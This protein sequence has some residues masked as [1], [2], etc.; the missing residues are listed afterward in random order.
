MNWVAIINIFGTINGLFFALVF[1][2][3]KRGNK[4]ANRILSLLFVN[5]ALISTGAFLSN[6]QLYQ[7]YTFLQRLGSPWFLAL[8]PLL[9]L[10]VRHLVISDERSNSKV[11]LHFLPII[12]NYLYNIPFYLRS[13][14]DK[15]SFLHSGPEIDVLVFRFL[16][17]V[18]FAVYTYL[19]FKDLKIYNKT[20]KD[21]YSSIESRQLNWILYLGLSILST[22]IVHTVFIGKI[23]LINSLFN[24]WETLIIMFLAFIGF[25]HPLIFSD[26]EFIKQ[27]I[28]IDKPVLPIDRQKQYL[29]LII[30]YVESKKIFLDSQ[31][32]LNKFSKDLG[33]PVSY[34]SNVINSQLKKNFFDFINYY[35]IEEAKSRLV[36]KGGNESILNIAFEVGFN[37]KSSF[38]SVFKKFVK[39]TPSQ[40]RKDNTK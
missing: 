31:L 27:L 28:R 6:A 35:R 2:R 16:Y 30:N 15:I 37:S 32:N 36:E 38:N 39:K 7:K 40:Y 34:C 18:H 1:F 14:D 19:I 26:Q 3:I 5:F 23:F 25:T 24:I 33:I 12:F 8:G 13:A 29:K 4:K 20:L 17:I 10:Y 22:M 11:Y 9:Y 21:G